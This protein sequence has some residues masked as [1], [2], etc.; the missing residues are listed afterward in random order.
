M[1][2]AVT[3]ALGCSKK[4]DGK[5]KT[6][7]GANKPAAAA[8]DVGVPCTTADCALSVGKT[9]VKTGSRSIALQSVRLIKRHRHFPA[10][11]L[12]MD[13]LIS[14]ALL[15]AEARKN[16]ITVSRDQVTKAVHKGDVVLLG[17]M[18]DGKRIYFRQGVFDAKS[19]DRFV[20]H[21][22]APSMD[23]FL[24]EQEL[25]HL[26][27]KVAIDRVK[28]TKVT[29][30]D[31]RDY[32]TKFHT[33]VSF[34]YVK[35]PVA[36]SLPHSY[37]NAKQ[38]ADYLAS[39][40]AKVKASYDQ[41]KHRY[42]GVSKQVQVRLVFVKR[43]KPG[44]KGTADPGFAIAQAVH[45]KLAAG[46][47]FAKLA[48]ETSDDLM[49]RA[50]GGDVGWRGRKHLGYGVDL[51]KAVGALPLKKLSDVVA[52]RRGFYIVRFDAERGG[53]LSFDQVKLEIAAKLAHRG[54]AIARAES[55]AN[56]AAAK[57]KTGTKV[58]TMFNTP[59]PR[60][61]P[62]LTPDMIKKLK[63]NKN[64]DPAML[65]KL[66]DAQKEPPKQLRDKAGKLLPE[67]VSAGPI[68]RDKFIPGLDGGKSTVDLVFDKAP[69]GEWTTARIGEDSLLL[70]VNKRTK[71]DWDKFETDKPALKNFLS[72]SNGTKAM[73]KWMMAACKKA[74]ADKRVNIAKNFQRVTGDDRKLV[75]YVPCQSMKP[76]K[77]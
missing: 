40:T 24:A 73:E 65:K 13:H 14:R 9:V 41:N 44:T 12:A 47:D 61:M 53:D 26:A 11:S 50:T 21:L 56:A 58:E 36:A 16:N 69:L 66:L 34:D 28:S 75:K 48:A 5:A 71:P 29:A 57:L 17:L 77:H 43:R 64:M 52:T 72:Q 2:V 39:N 45:K 22:G 35:Y 62:K 74:V 33:T 54:L 4:D 51:V 19:L 25:E 30:K 32:Y 67:R 46:A 49:S 7:P 38:A 23:A 70:K 68:R 42:T 31:L 10:G 27:Y 55:L 37:A 8:V 15:V 59:R 20:R 6:K 1:C 3:L 76:D 63:A 60:G 18:L